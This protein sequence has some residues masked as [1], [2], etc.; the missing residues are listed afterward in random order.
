MLLELSF[1]AHSIEK[2]DIA[3]ELEPSYSQ[4]KLQIVYQTSLTSNIQSALLGTF[5][6]T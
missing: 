6:T 2:L 3:K 1:Q 4:Y 5:F